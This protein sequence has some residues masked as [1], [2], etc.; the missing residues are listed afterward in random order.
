MP[1]LAIAPPPLLEPPP[2][3]PANTVYV[4]EFIITAIVVG[5]V[6]PVP[7]LVPFTVP[8][9]LIPPALPPAPVA[10]TVLKT[11]FAPVPPTVMV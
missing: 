5:K 4:I 7:P 6:G 3:P 11:L 1:P 10:V 2:P 9:L 8:A